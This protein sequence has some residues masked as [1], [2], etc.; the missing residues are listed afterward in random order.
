MVQRPRTQIEINAYRRRSMIEGTL[1]S[2]AENGIAGTTVRS[3]C[4]GEAGSRGLIAHYY[5]S[6]EEL[7]AAAFVD[8]MQTINDTVQRAQARCGDD[9][10]KRLN[11]LPKAMFSTEVFTELNRGAFLTFWHEVRFNEAVR[12]SNQLSYRD[13][14][15]E[16][17]ELFERSAA[18]QQV[19]IDPDAA[20]LGLV[21]MIDG[22]WLEMSID[23]RVTSRRKAVKLCCDYISMQLRR[24]GPR[25]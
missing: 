16:V 8:L 13:Y 25:E 12:K 15:A 7:L 21:A 6:K 9:P 19:Q 10:V 24:D 18:Q 2:L 14:I 4:G 17:S 1:R 11:A 20:A 3:I 22:L 5:S 23:N